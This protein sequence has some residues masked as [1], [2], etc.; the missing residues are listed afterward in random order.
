MVDDAEQDPLGAG[1]GNQRCAAGAVCHV[2]TFKATTFSPIESGGVEQCT[3]GQGIGVIGD[4]LGIGPLDH[5]DRRVVEGRDDAD[6]RVGQKLP[7]DAGVPQRIDGHL[8]R[9]KA[10]RVTARSNGCL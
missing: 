9:I 4:E 6:R 2:G 5:H 7:H 8:S 1:S 3:A 10:G